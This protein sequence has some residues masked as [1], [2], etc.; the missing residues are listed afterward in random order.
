MPDS[1][2]GRPTP[3][4]V[5][6][7]PRTIALLVGVALGSLAL[8]AV[9][10]TV[11][12]VLV[13]LVVAVVLAMAAE[14]LVQALQR[15]GLS[16]GTAVGVSFALGAALVIGF[17][18]L[19]VA[20][21]VHETRQLAH[22]APALVDQL[23]HGEGRYGFLEERFHVVERARAALESDPASVTA[24]PVVGAVGS[25]VSTAGALLFIAFLTLFVQLGGRRWFDSLVGLAPE[26]AGRRIRRAGEG[27]STAVGGYVAGNLL[28][29]VVA[30]TVTTIVLLATGVPYA[31]PL[32][33]LVGIL[34]LIPMVGATIGT[35]VAAAVALT[36]SLPTAVIV[37][38]A[39]VLYQ[40]IENH[41]LQQLVY[42][43]TVKLSPL[44]ISLS[45][46]IGAELGGVAGALLGIPF[47]GALKAVSDELLAWRRGE[48]PDE[49]P[50]V[51]RSESVPAPMRA[52][53]PPADHDHGELTAKGV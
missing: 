30:G 47:A 26:G 21:L 43:R 27:I 38:A 18:Y 7:A 33:V 32:G 4:A 46:A 19:M 49:G 29:S 53:P 37:V 6:V 42:H 5:T 20:P 45:V 25:A 23:T 48:E 12:E 2:D 11:R 22:D 13:Q 41:S 36:V 15:R 39:M 44:A 1:P 31:V 28:I 35:V 24:G 51:L 10:W 34:D 8:V 9:V 40:Q 14:P 50:R 17:V 3:V 52:G 16:R